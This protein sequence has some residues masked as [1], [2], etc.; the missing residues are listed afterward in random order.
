MREVLLFRK[1]PPSRYRM[2]AVGLSFPIKE[3]N[4]NR[5]NIELLENRNTYKSQSNYNENSD[6]LN[7]TLDKKIYK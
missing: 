7:H 4:T 1:R 5:K 2:H 6:L 3:I